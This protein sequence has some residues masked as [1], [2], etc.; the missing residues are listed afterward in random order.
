MALSRLERLV[1]DKTIARM[2]ACL[3]LGLGTSSHAQQTPPL[4]V[5][6]FVRNEAS[7]L[8]YVELSVAYDA[9]VTQVLIG[10][11]HSATEEIHAQRIVSLL[12]AVGDERAVD[13]LIEYIE[14]PA[15]GRLSFEQNQARKAAIIGL[16]YVINRTGSER[17]LSYLIDGLTPSVW[18]R[19]VHGTP[20]W[21]DSPNYEQHSN[22]AILGLALSG[23]PRAGQALRSL[24]QTLTP[25]PARIGGLYTTVKQWL[26]VHDLVAER[27]VTGMYEY[28]KTQEQQRLEAEAAKALRDAN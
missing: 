4:D 19:R 18:S 6:D 27:G 13:A 28:Y 8:T 7:P 16:G 5:R 26:E 2:A 14:K 25:Q 12:A 15:A 23:H 9:G 22:W 10:M 11:L 20:P 17:A 1:I 24:Q 3:V 21:T